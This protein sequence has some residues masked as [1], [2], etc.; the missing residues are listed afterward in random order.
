MTD[1]P[2]PL[3]IDII[4]DVVCPWCI[5]GYRQLAAALEATGINHEIHWH[6]FELNP[7]MPQEGQNLGEHIAEKYGSTRQQSLDGR[8]RLTAIG[9]DLGFE[10]NFTDDMRM[11]NTFNAH[12]LIHWADTQG[13]GHAL[14]QALFSAYFTDRRDLSDHEVLAGVA[15]EVGLDSTQARAVLADQRYAEDVRQKEDF[16]VEQG[17]QGVPAMVFDRKHLV[18]GA[19]GSENYT[20]ILNQLAATPG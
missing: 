19:Q 2:Q 5:V 17:I 15:Q 12:Q 14:K 6:P 10:F 16:W 8:A 11:H 3:R 18:T 13:L 9:N 1:S 4:S 7:Q 20:S